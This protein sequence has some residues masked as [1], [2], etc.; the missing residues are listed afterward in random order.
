MKKNKKILCR[1]SSLLLALLVLVGV[2]ATAPFTAGA[3]TTTKNEKSYE[4]AVVFDNSGSMYLPDSSGDT[5][6]WSRAKYAMEIFAS[7]LDYGKDGL[8]VFPMWEVTTDGTT[9]TGAKG[10][11]TKPIEIKKQGDIDK[12]T[13]MYT[14]FAAGTPFTPVEKAYDHLMKSGKDEKWLIVLT[15][16]AF[17][18]VSTVEQLQD[19]LL[20]RA[21]NG[22]KVQ[23][24]GFGEAPSLNADVSKGFYAP[25]A[26][27]LEAKLIEAC[28]TIFQRSILP[29][30][31]LN[32][33]EL[34]LDLSMKKLIVFVQGQGATVKSL[35]DSGGKQIG[36]TLDSKQRKFSDVK[37]SAGNYVGKC[38]TD[39][40]LYGQ[41]V[42]FEA[43]AKGKYT[44]DYTGSQDAVQIF[45]EPDVDIEITFTNSDGEVVDDPENFYAGEYT[46]NTKIV[47][48]STREDVTNHELMGK[49]VNL[50]TKVKTSK[51]SSYKE[52]PNGSKI[53][54]APDDSTEVVVEGEYLGKYKISTKDDPKWDW[55]TGLKVPEPTPKFQ[56]D[57]QVLQDGKWY[58]IKNRDTW[59]PI[60]VSMLL[61]GQPLTDEQM[62]NTK[63]SIADAGT[64]KYRSEIIPGESA[65]NVYIAQDESGQFV[66][67]DVGS[68]KLKISATYVDEYQKEHTS[69]EAKV[70]FDIEKYEKWKK[71]LAIIILILLIL[72]LIAAWLLHPVLPKKIIL[73][74]EN[75]AFTKNCPIS[76]VPGR[77]D[78][79]AVAISGKP[80]V[81]RDMRNS[82]IMSIIS[83][84]RQNY[85]LLNPRSTN[86]RDLTVDGIQYTFNGSKMYDAE[87][88]VVESI[89]ISNSDISWQETRNNR[90]FSGEIR[91]NRR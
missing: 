45:Y 37:Y 81:V 35:S 36:I 9:P 27:T 29:A 55:I 34:N 30:N 25:T 76:K 1:I 86:V 31:R 49:D 14:V 91:I 6:A 5:R 17:D 67:P 13:K 80:A 82:W 40:T 70:S 52:Y 89:K 43:C 4:I 15:D 90:S 79:T 78:L 61:E 77:Y 59:K 19:T 64:L 38:D 3:T 72:A 63:L 8:T 2:F 11:S 57:A 16:G 53:T 10:E 66:E 33:K 87:G 74:S 71:V 46:V 28:N 60:K 44:L 54:F 68:Y 62:A 50:V 7:M 18:T 58:T 24:L 69:N 75:G 23:Y 83:P 73:A 56:I 22:V 47:D 26:S 85:K 42:T 20:Q 32:G 12:L 84:K 48:S 88:E 51:D 41:V 39:Q 21:S 65:Y